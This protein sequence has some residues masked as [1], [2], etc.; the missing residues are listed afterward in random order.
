MIAVAVD[1]SRLVHTAALDALHLTLA[2]ALLLGRIF[3]ILDIAGYGIG[4][5][6]GAALERFA[7]RAAERQRPLSE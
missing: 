3:S 5:L 6:I 7:V 1:L 4:I 2:G